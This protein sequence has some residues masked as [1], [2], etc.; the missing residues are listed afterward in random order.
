MLRDVFNMNADQL[1]K[2]GVVYQGFVPKND[3]PDIKNGGN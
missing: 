3:T 2:A 1:K